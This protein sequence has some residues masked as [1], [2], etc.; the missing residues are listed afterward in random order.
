MDF[1]DDLSTASDYL[2]MAVPLM[3]RRRIPPTPYNYALWY[4]HVQNASPELSR[5]LLAE[6]PE[7]GPYHPEISEA[8]FLS[9]SSSITCP[10]ARKPAISLLKLSRN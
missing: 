2:R 10:V 1:R 5:A 3:V 8:L 7:S 6:F 4:A 9:T